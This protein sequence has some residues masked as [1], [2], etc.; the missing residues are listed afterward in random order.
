M[1]LEHLSFLPNR[2][3]LSIHALAHVLVGEPVST[4]PGH[5]LVS[6]S[7]TPQVEGGRIFERALGET[8]RVDRARRMPIRLEARAAPRLG[9]VGVDREGFVAAAARMGDVIDAAAERT[10]AP[11]VD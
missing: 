11:G 7:R 1:A 8:G 9:L 4:S 2:E 5:A 6:L 3:I 10:A